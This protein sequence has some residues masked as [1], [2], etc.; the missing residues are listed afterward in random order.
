MRQEMRPV[1]N[2]FLC[3]GARRAGMPRQQKR[4]IEMSYPHRRPLQDLQIS[5]QRKPH[6]IGT[7]FTSRKIRV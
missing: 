3:G 5:K 1:H 2:F 6:N 7:S 4:R